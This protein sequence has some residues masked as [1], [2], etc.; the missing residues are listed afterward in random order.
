MRDYPV[1]WFY[2]EEIPF[3]G[4]SVSN[5]PS[6]NI[7]LNSGFKPAWVEIGAQKTLM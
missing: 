7:A 6:W 4:T 5:Y 1:R 3:Y 2:D